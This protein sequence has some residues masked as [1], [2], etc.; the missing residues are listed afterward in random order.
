M[1]KLILILLLLAPFVLFAQDE[2][3]PYECKIP[4]GLENRESMKWF[5]DFQDKLAEYMTG[6]KAP[7]FQVMSVDSQYFDLAALKGKVVVLNFWYMSCPPCRAEI[8]YLDKVVKN[9]KRKDVVFISFCSDRADRVKEL[10]AQKPF[11]YNVIGSSAEI[12]KL[13]NICSYPTNVVIDKQ[14][15]IRLFKQGAFMGK[16][17]RIVVNELSDAIDQCLY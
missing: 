13:Y 2:V 3:K 10:L 5:N 16:M 14:G 9:Y 15:V 8:P 7:A 12:Q 6:K 4:E 17:N 1:R 11:S